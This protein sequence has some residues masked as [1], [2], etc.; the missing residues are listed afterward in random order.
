MFVFGFVCERD[1][2]LLFFFSAIRLQYTNQTVTPW[3]SLHGLLLPRF[4]LFGSGVL[5]IEDRF[6][7]VCR[8]FFYVLCF[9][10][11]IGVVEQITKQFET[12]KIMFEF[13]HRLLTSWLMLST[14]AGRRLA[15]LTVTFH[16]KRGQ[17]VELDTNP[18][19]K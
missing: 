15:E 11:L 19:C 10:F 6:E 16:Y 13:D 3:R 12:I 7:S 4:L 18:K 5:D 8:R 14:P 9:S 17:L 1:F 2:V